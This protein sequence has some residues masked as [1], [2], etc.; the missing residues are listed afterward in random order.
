MEAR[1]GGVFVAHSMDRGAL[2]HSAVPIAY[3]EG[4]GATAIAADEDHV[5]V[6]YQDPNAGSPRVALAISATMG[7]IFER[8]LTVSGADVRATAPQT[9]LRGSLVA[10]S[11]IEQG[12]GAGAGAGNG[13]ADTVRRA[14]AVRMGVIEWATIPKP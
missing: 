2:F 3:G 14:R 8:H 5:V 12:E 7:H 4:F 9:A 10:V 1:E 11:W 6:A 13:G